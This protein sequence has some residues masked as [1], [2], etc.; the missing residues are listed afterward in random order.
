[1][2]ND[3][4][5]KLIQPGAFDDQLTEILRQGARTLLAQAVQGTVTDGKGQRVLSPAGWWIDGQCIVWSTRS[6]ILLMKS[7]ARAPSFS[8]TWSGRS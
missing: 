6:P 3:N 4:V 5:F 7:M 1:V 8:E 2:S